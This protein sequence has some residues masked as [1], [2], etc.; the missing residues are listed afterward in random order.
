MM[1]QLANEHLELG[2]DLFSLN[3]VTKI[4]GKQK[5]SPWERTNSSV[6]KSLLLERLIIWSL[7]RDN[8]ASRI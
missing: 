3:T 4:G 6:W 5:F 1:K 8:K 2:N 7:F